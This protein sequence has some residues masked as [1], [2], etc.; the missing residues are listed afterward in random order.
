MSLT[1]L[2]QKSKISLCSFN[3]SKYEII[4]LRVQW[5]NFVTTETLSDDWTKLFYQSAKSS[6]RHLILS[7][8]CRESACTNI[9][10]TAFFFFCHRVHFC[11]H[12]I[13]TRKMWVSIQPLKMRCF[14]KQWGQR[15]TWAQTRQET[16]EMP[17]KKLEARLW[18][19]TPRPAGREGVYSFLIEEYLETLILET[20]KF[21]IT[22]K[23]VYWKQLLF[24]VW[25]KLWGK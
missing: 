12:L 24:I 9:I 11:M 1:R 22:C 23:E 18:D 6:R 8:L 21:P 3:S 25:Y 16:F 20:C 13:Y 4:Q 14:Y 5:G 17:Q 19:L 7:V 2:N 10:P 15:P